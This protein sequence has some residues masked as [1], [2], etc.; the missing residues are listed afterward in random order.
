MP[1]VHA[2]P[3]FAFYVLIHS[4]LPL[5]KYMYVGRTEALVPCKKSMVNSWVGQIHDIWKIPVLHLWSL[6]IDHS[7]LW[8]PT[9]S[10]FPMS[11]EASRC[12]SGRCAWEQDLNSWHS[13]HRVTFFSRRECN[14][15][16]GY[17]PHWRDKHT[18]FKQHFNG[19][20]PQIVS[21][22]GFKWFDKSL[23]LAFHPVGSGLGISF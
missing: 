16:M 9:K 2:H 23:M 3:S 17:T 22:S 14:V 10:L 20:W 4:F 7:N 8:M 15:S 12:V 11:S 13:S 5:K 19:S 6:L 1:A 21:V 18:V